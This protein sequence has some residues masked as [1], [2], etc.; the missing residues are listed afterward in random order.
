MMPT[1]TLSRRG[2][3]KGRPHLGHL[4]LRSRRP[5]VLRAPPGTA[6]L[7]ER[8]T[9]TSASSAA[10]GLCTLPSVS[11]RPVVLGSDSPSCFRMCR[12]MRWTRESADRAT[13]DRADN[14]EDDPVT[15]LFS[16]PTPIPTDLTSLR[17]SQEQL[18]RRKHLA[19]S[20]ADAPGSFAERLPPQVDLDPGS[21]RSRDG[22]GRPSSERNQ[23]MRSRPRAL[24]KGRPRIRRN[25]G[26][27]RSAAVEPTP[28]LDAV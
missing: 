20:V 9:C 17:A 14:R 21:D 8:F 24:R 13:R 22:P 27:G 16:F 10:A 6:G 11:A 23:A 18:Y 2:R 5:A 4:R 26:P 28:V 1:P 12:R 19:S 7:H 15:A 3:Q 25:N